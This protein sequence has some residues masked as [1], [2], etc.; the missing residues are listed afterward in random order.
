ML[1]EQLEYYWSSYVLPVVTL[2]FLVAL[3]FA[4]LALVDYGERAAGQ[5]ARMSNPPSDFLVYIEVGTATDLASALAQNPNVELV[6][7]DAWRAAEAI[8][9]S[10][11]LSMTLRNLPP[12]EL[13][14]QALA[15]GEYPTEPSQIAVTYQLAEALDVDIDSYLTVTGDLGAKRYLI[16][17]IYARSPFDD[18][19]DSAFEGL[20][21]DAYP[22][23]VAAYV[24]DSG[25]GG[26]EVK[27]TSA[28]AAQEVMDDVLTIGNSVVIQSHD[29]EELILNRHNR[30]LSAITMAVPWLVITG[31]FFATTVLVLGFAASG[32][33]RA[34]ERRNLRSLGVKPHRVLG[35]DIAELTVVSGLGLVLGIAL[36]LAFSFG[37]VEFLRSVPG[38]HFMP[39]NLHAPGHAFVIATATLIAA[40]GIAVPVARGIS[41]TD[42]L[43]TCRNRPLL[44]VPLSVIVA[45]VAIYWAGLIPHV[46]P[47]LA[48]AMDRIITVAII[49]VLISGIFTL[50]ILVV[51]T[52]T[53]RM[54]IGACT[55]LM[56]RSRV[57]L[58]RLLTLLVIFLAAGALGMIHTTTQ[59]L[60]G[61]D[62]SL[63]D[64]FDVAVRSRLGKSALADHQIS[65]VRTWQDADRTLSLRSIETD[66]PAYTPFQP[67]PIYAVDPSEA[68]AYFGSS[69]GLDSRLL[70]PLGTE[71]TP[72]TISF[73]YDDADRAVHTVN[74]EVVEANVPVALVSTKDVPGLEIDEMWVRLVPN[75]LET[76]SQTYPDFGERLSSH[77]PSTR[78][79]ITLSLSDNA[80]RPL[81]TGHLAMVI[82]SSIFA[83]FAF[84]AFVRVPRAFSLYEFEN[85]NLRALGL[86]DRRRRFRRLG[87]A[88]VSGAI[89][90]CA[91]SVVGIVAAGLV[92]SNAGV[93]G[94]ALQA[95]WSALTAN[96]AIILLAFMTFGAISTRADVAQATNRAN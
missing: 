95:P 39:E 40:V 55:H 49:A 72:G 23:Y 27:G 48:G 45:A 36:G 32:Q 65:V 22:H 14:T 56:P 13:R 38:S 30:A 92:L 96:L 29:R 91:G 80:P 69:L 71:G 9:A 51:G 86:S 41:K 50:A 52:L 18:R 62:V 37:V 85:R 44:L 11:T 82:Q 90:L 43:H 12:Q 74:L 15:R 47:S 89:M 76:L 73:H 34:V 25:Q 17:G 60:I 57:G 63:Q 81:N 3:T 16:T 78:P 67:G 35:M 21:L 2:V 5:S 84:V 94:V 6:H 70:V 66:L 59:S 20:V 83:L 53:R 24:D 19:L 1:R 10:G 31:F 64:R 93:V 68:E 58:I 28:M 61:D 26:I 77:T 33:Q 8:S 4:S 87:D 42:E 79:V 88:I 75:A 46:H 54:K 7:V